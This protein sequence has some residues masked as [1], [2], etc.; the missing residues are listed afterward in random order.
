MHL[1]QILDNLIK[2]ISANTVTIDKLSAT[3]VA[4]VQRDLDQNIP[5]H[6]PAAVGDQMPQTVV[7]S[8]TPPPAV[9]EIDAEPAPAETKP[10]NAA[11]CKELVMLLAK[12]DRPAAIKI[13]DDYGVKNASS[14]E[15]GQFA[16]FI[17][18]MTAALAK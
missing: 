16:G 9:V 1:E 7:A 5:Q 13:L 3:I 2:S 10:V 6:I 18:D 4:L 11:T 14:L 15:E 8:E 12:V 17:A